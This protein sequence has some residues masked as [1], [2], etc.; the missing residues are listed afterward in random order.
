MAEL[1]APKVIDLDGFPVRVAKRTKERSRSIEG[2]H[3]TARG[4]VADENRTAHGAEIRRCLR[5]TPGRVKGAVNREVLGHRAVRI[6]NV[7]KSTLRLVKGREVPEHR[8]VRNFS[9][10]PDR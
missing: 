10:S 4:V 1:D 9:E 3:S 2:V 7:Y 5:D 8:T 6:E